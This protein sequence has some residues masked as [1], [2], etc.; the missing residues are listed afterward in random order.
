MFS[1]I[2]HSNENFLKGKNETE[3]IET[4]YLDQVRHNEQLR[5]SA[6]LVEDD[7]SQDIN[8]VEEGPRRKT[9]AINSD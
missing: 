4:I 6:P 1:K 8:V 7:A 5:E 9:L 2:W 3:D